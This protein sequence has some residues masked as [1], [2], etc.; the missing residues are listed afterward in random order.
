MKKS[1]LA[2][3]LA[4]ALPAIAQAQS[5]IVLY[6]IVDGAIEYANQ[7]ANSSS[8]QLGKSGFR[9]SSSVGTG[10]RLGVRGSENLGGGLSA[11]FQIEHR[12][13]LDTGDT[14][15]GNIFLL[16]GQTNSTLNNKFWNGLSMAGLRG[17]WGQVT[18]GRQYTPLY[19]VV[20]PADFS[21]YMYYNNWQGSQGDSFGGTVGSSAPIGPTRTDNSI[22]Y[23]SPS[24]GG[25]TVYATYAFG[26]NYYGNTP[27]NTTTGQIGSDLTG[28]QDVWGVGAGWKMGGL[29]IGGG[30][31][32]Y[33]NKP[34]WY[35][36]N[37]GTANSTVYKNVWAATASYNFGGF[38][39][40]LGYSKSEFDQAFYNYATTV[41]TNYKPSLENILLS[42]FVNLGPGKLILNAYQTEFKGW[43]SSATA[44]LRNGS[45]LQLG[46]AYAWP[47]S[48]RTSIY[49]A[50]GMNDAS[51][52]QTTTAI[53]KLDDRQRYAVGLTHRF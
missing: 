8:S 33:S 5:S 6:G 35:S 49:A 11:I 51:I 38:G 39:L 7:N 48:N 31:Q 27:N 22:K 32:D 41:R 24:F 34:H 44:P 12:F 19:D 14:A 25:L 4:A 42:A 3:A 30:Y 18:L 29:Y 43:Y 40:S 26:E 47:L 15:G 53:N 10:T 2:L 16:P 50:L 21:A 1:I 37:T 20:A 23:V 28:T 45:G 46:L 36:G 52:N 13:N 9:V 17:G